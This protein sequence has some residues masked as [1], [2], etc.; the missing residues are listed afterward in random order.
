M[1]VLTLKE[2]QYL[3]EHSVAC[4]YFYLVSWVIS[5]DVKFEFRTV[6]CLN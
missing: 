6:W 2:L 1:I 5:K 3:M 4:N